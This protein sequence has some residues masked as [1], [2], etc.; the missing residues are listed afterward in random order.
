[1]IAIHRWIEGSS[2]DVLVVANLQEQTRDELTQHGTFAL[3]RDNVNYMRNSVKA[4]VDAY[5]GTV[6]FYVVDP[7][8]PIIQT[9]RKAFP[10]LF[11]DLSAMPAELRAH[12]RY[13]E[14]IF[15]AQTEQYALYHITDPVQYFNKQAIWDIAPSPDASS[16]APV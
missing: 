1:V 3:A 13:P 16:A 12:M 2:Q 14:D 6:H 5:D 15:S 4:T 9:Y 10:E 8:D 7:K 11:Q